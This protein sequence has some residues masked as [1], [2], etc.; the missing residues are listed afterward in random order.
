MRIGKRRDEI[1]TAIDETEADVNE[2]LSGLEEAEEIAAWDA[3]AL[4][5][6]DIEKLQPAV[7]ET[8]KALKELSAGLA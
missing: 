6:Q 7:I 2:I 1:V 4:S 5:K 3:E 8:V